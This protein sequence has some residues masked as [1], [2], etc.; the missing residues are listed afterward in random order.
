[1]MRQLN[2]KVALST[3]EVLK[4]AFSPQDRVFF[5]LTT[6]DQFFPHSFTTSTHSLGRVLRTL[7]D[8]WKL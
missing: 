1:M 4:A 6:I 8:L 5:L 7:A 3:I 2:K